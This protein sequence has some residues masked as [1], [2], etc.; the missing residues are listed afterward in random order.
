MYILHSTLRD[1][2]FFEGPDLESN[3]A[4]VLFVRLL[5]W[6]NSRVLTLYTNHPDGNFQHKY[7]MI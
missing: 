2:S 1:F 7:K 6:V 3:G 5:N 4:L